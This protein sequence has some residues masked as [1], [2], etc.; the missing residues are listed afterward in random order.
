MADF[1][2]SLRLPAAAKYLG[3][4]DRTFRDYAIESE[5]LPSPTGGKPIMVYR[6]SV[7][8]KFREDCNNPKCRRPLLKRRT[9]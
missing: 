6:V 1:D 2:P 8:N 5:T 4:S 7:L 3:V 9:A